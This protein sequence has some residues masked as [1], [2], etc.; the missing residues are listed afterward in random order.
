VRHIDV[1]QRTKHRCFA[2]I[3]TE[4]YIMTGGLDFFE[5][6]DGS[7][8]K[9]R[10]T[11]GSCTVGVRP[12]N[13]LLYQ[14]PNVCSC[15]PQV[16]GFVAFAGD[17]SIAGRKDEPQNAEFRQTGT[18]KPADEV[19]SPD[20]W[21]MFRHDP[22][23]SGSTAVILPAEVTPAWEEEI[24]GR[25]SSPV[26]A[27]GKV[28][29]SS[30][31]DHRVIA[32]DLKTGE[33]VWSYRA[34]GRVDSPPTIY[35]GQ[36][37]FGCRDGWLYCVSSATGELVWSRLAVPRQRW[38]VCLGQ[39]ES[40]WPLHGSVL[41][42]ND[43]AYFAAG[44]HTEVDGGILLCAASPK[45][46]KALWQKQL[47]CSEATEY[48]SGSTANDVL[49]SDGPA[50][51][52]ENSRFDAK[53][54]AP[55]GT[56]R[57]SMSGVADFFWGGSCG[58][59]TDIARPPA[60]WH[61]NAKRPWAI[62]SELGWPHQSRGIALTFAGQTVFGIRIVGERAWKDK[63]VRC[64]IFSCSKKEG[65]KQTFWQAALPEGVLPKALLHAGGKL[66]VAAERG[67]DERGKGTILIYDAKGGKSLGNVPLDI[68]PRFDGMAAVKGKLIVVGQDGKI[69]CLAGK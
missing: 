47:F 1:K 66:Y 59:L 17:A 63:V 35:G 52:M 46:G 49:L 29:V 56:W 55:K 42:D 58:F 26:V 34:N 50:I 13:G 43:T 33:R 23:R 48:G 44:R 6:R 22:G 9:F 51:Y 67:S 21:P 5:I 24:G 18:G 39:V 8:S 53:T 61:E 54:G 68:R 7:H 31:D 62:S 41:I 19:A 45:T 30:I 38:L 3:A 60:G 25:L 64:E 16:R 28:F 57:G 2:D 40:A 15:F 36:A 37:I 10:A 4:K 65:T 14:P 27:C 32:R 11:K 20:D 12:A 69:T